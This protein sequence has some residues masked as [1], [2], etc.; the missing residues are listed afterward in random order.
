[1]TL[2]LM[3]SRSNSAMAP[4][5]RAVPNDE[6]ETAVWLC[7]KGGDA[8]GGRVA[9]RPDGVIVFLAKRSGEIGPDL[10]DA[11]AEG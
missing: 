11:S 8:A 9:Q 6:R 5:Y 10:P 1:M 7:G 3:S 2:S 4:E